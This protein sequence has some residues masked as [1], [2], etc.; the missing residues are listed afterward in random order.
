M[1]S[2]S[3]AIFFGVL[4]WVVVAATL[5]VS[6]P[7]MTSDRGLYDSIAAVVI[8][9]S[10]VT[11]SA[12]Y[13]R[14]ASG[15]VLRESVYLSVT[16]AVVIAGLDVS[17]LMLGVLKMSLSRFVSDVAVSYLMTP[18]ITIGMGYMKSQMRVEGDR[19]MRHF[20]ETTP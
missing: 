15:P 17:M 9:L 2:I 11:F 6:L 12:L 7:L 19:T 20:T 13:L 16:F 4:L 1:H 8:S 14:D 10:L 18:I 5:L 3:K